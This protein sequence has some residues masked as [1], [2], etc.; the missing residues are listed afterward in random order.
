MCRDVNYDLGF[1]GPPTPRSDANLC[2]TLNDL[3]TL[4]ELRALNDEDIF[5]DS[6]VKD[7][8]G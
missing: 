6:L 7:F 2:Q 5:F 4:E 1:M 3:E 8:G